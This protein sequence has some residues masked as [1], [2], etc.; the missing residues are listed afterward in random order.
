MGDPVRG[1][2]IVLDRR[3]GYCLICHKVPIPDEFFQGDVGPDLSGVGSRL[4]AAQIRLRLVD[5][6]RLNP[7]TLMPPYHR[8]SGLKRVPERYRGMV[9]LSAQEVED[10][11]AWLSTLR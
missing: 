10:V 8:T 2:A 6:A 11:V 9:V 4:S 3:T 1:M 7:A 5:A